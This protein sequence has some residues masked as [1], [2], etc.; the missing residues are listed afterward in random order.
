VEVDVMDGLEMTL[1]ALKAKLEVLSASPQLSVH[2]ALVRMN[3]VVELVSTETLAVLESEGR[4]EEAAA[5]Y[6]KVAEAFAIAA[7]KVPEE[8]R[9]R[10]ISWGNYWSLKASTV[11]LAPQL[12][13]EPTPS[14]PPY[15]EQRRDP[16]TDRLST[17]LQ[18]QDPF[19][20]TRAYKPSAIV[21]PQEAVDLKMPGEVPTGRGTEVHTPPLPKHIKR[22]PTK[23][24]QFLR[25][26]PQP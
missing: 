5:L 8:D 25:K 23:S 6:G 13:P 17:K 14:P 18:R 11:R 20:V 4:F 12:A 2:E 22:V 1:S 16:V 26:K 15:A 3:E 21:R 19:S 7:Q 10:V 24:R 9:Q